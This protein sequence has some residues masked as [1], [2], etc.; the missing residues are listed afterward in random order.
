ML[1]LPASTVLGVLIPFRAIYENETS[2]KHHIDV[3]RPE[4]TITQG[5]V[6]REEREDGSN[7]G[8]CRLKRVDVMRLIGRQGQ[9][10][11]MEVDDLLVVQ[12]SKQGRVA[13]S[14]VR[15]VF[16]IETQVIPPLIQV[17]SEKQCL[18][19]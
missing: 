16:A 4:V 5:D 8:N 19:G 13:V 2:E 3:P 6:F 10:W 15:L 1:N 18:L 7:R 11:T 9:C 14:R 17:C 12:A